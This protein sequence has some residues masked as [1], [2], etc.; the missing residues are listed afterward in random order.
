[1]PAEG[2]GARDGGIERGAGVKM[3]S[4]AIASGAAGRRRRAGGVRDRFCRIYRPAMKIDQFFA[5]RDTG[6]DEKDCEL[7]PLRGCTRMPLG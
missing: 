7:Y 3:E 2:K 6:K 5:A 4:F 1:M